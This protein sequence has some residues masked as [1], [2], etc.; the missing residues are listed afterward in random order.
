MRGLQENQKETYLVLQT[1][2]HFFTKTFLCSNWRKHGVTR[3]VEKFDRRGIVLLLV[4]KP[5]PVND[6]IPN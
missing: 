6:D 5:F 3:P 2:I 1:K 4:K